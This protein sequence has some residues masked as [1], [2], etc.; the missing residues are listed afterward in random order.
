VGRKIRDKQ[1]IAVLSEEGPYPVPFLAARESAMHEQNSL[2]TCTVVRIMRELYL[3][4]L[5]LRL[6]TTFGSV[7]RGQ[8]V[9]S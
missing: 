9:C 1:M 3:V 6:L 5:I 7:Q 8:D 4:M 2:V